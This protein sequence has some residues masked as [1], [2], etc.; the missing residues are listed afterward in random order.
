MSTYTETVYRY[1][2]MR[3][4]NDAARNP[5]GS[6]SLVFSTMDAHIALDEM[7]E[8]VKTWGKFGD[9]FKIVDAGKVTTIERNAHF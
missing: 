1:R 8:Q 6:W 4:L 2:V 7:I 9:A 3:Q 5:E